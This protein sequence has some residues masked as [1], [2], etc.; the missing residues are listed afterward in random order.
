MRRSERLPN[1]ILS[2][3]QSNMPRLLN[4]YGA[5]DLGRCRPSNQDQFLIAD[6]NRA[7]TVNQSSLASDRETSLVGAPQGKVLLVADGMGGHMA[8]KRASQLAVDST[9]QY[10][11]NSLQWLFPLGTADDGGFCEQLKSAMR[12]C[13]AVL[14]Q[15]AKLIP[16][17]RGMGTTLTLAYVVWPR[18]YVVHA[19]DSRCY[20]LRGERMQQITRDHTLSQLYR[21]S[22]QSNSPH[23]ATKE[24]L[25]NSALWNVV[26]SED[27]L[28]PEVYR[29]NLD[30][31][32]QIFLCTDGL[33]KHI[34]DELMAS[35]L[36]RAGSPESAC[37][38]LIEEANRRGGSDNIT[39]IVA[40]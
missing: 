20:V 32:D 6:L 7:M 38:G 36:S 26:S 22:R 2:L 24:A 16:Q 10:I 12:H 13:Q 34:D 40:V 23:E 33:Y 19:G 31:G 14:Q 3:D 21:E 15:E 4:C 9:V 1:S 8:G 25:W 17:R 11:L 39:A 35:M 5:T 28:D 37:D 29:F 18:M 30:D 27:E